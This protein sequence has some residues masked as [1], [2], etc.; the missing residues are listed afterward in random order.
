MY[1]DDKERNGKETPSKCYKM[2]TQS[3]S[4]RIEHSPPKAGVQT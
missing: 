2:D 4:L 3:K 1:L